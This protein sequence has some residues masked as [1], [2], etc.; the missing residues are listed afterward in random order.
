MPYFIICPIYALLFIGLMLVS[1]VLLFIKRLR[2]WSSY[3]ALGAVGTIPGFIIGNV[4]FWLLLFGVASVVQ[5]PMQ[6]ISSSVLD[7]VAAVGL[8]LFFVGGLA[9]AN[10]GG[11]AAG[12]L[13]AVWIR[14]R[15]RR[16][17][18]A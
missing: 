1:V 9:V 17:D 4:L 12:F 18:A 8:V 16:K 2:H 10:I 15:F 14:Y 7:G 5:K 3:V 6:Q 13:G 11:C